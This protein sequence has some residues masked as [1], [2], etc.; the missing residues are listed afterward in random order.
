MA[1]YLLIHGAMCGAW[2]WQRVV[3]LLERARSY[4]SVGQ[5]VA[6]DLPGHGSRRRVN[7]AYVTLSDYVESVVDEMESRGMRDVVLVAHS[8]GGVLVPGVVSMAQDRV[9]RVVFISALVP[10]EGKCV[11]DLWRIPRWWRH[12][13]FRATGSYTKG[14]RAPRWYTRFAVGQD[15]DPETRKAFFEQRCPEPVLPMEEG[16][17][18]NGFSVPSTYLFLTRDRSLSPAQQRRMIMNLYNPDL[19]TLEAGHNVLLTHPEAV[20]EALLRYA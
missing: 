16:I 1:D 8:L 9:K 18:W 7:L 10:A 12:V 17:S 4:G 15:L 5:V 6:P 19:V 3:P 2:T 14:L 13:F 11:L 20:A